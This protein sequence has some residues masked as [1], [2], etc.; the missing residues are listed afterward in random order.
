MKISSA[1]K[2][3]RKNPVLEV[4][5]AKK[6]LMPTCL[7]QNGKVAKKKG[8]KGPKRS[9]QGRKKMKQKVKSIF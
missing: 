5:E 8:P 3:K 7:L 4:V 9:P 2:R 6:I 1:I